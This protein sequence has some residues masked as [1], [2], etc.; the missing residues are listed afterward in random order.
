M[1]TAVQNIERAIDALTP[2]QREQLAL[3]FEQHYPRS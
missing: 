3:W 2:R 1:D